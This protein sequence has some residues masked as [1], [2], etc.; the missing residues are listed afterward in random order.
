MENEILKVRKELDN[1]EISD[2]IDIDILQRFLDNFA[3]GMNIASVAV[4][5]NGT[6][7]TNPS[8]YTRI[9]SNYTHSTK[10][11]DD[12]CAECHK[13]GG[14][15]AAKSG[16]PY[17]FRC[18]A[19]LIDFAAPIMVQGRHIGTIL[20]G[21]TLTAAPDEEEFRKTAREI[22]VN[23]DE[24]VEAAKEIKI[25]DEKNIKAAAEVLFIVANALSQIGYSKLM[26]KFTSGDL[27]ENF[28]Q[29]SATMEELAASSVNMN[30]NQDKL[31][32]EIS[33][34][35]DISE[36]IIEILVSVKSI[37]DQTKLI[38]LNASIEAARAGQAGKVFS[39]VAE[40]IGNLSRNSKQTAVNIEKLTS[41]IS[42]SM[43][44]TLELSNSTM[45]NVEQQSAGIEE[46]TASIQEVLTL[47]NELYR[48]ANDK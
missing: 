25:K 6:P 1:I 22:G 28:S 18:H 26:I 44:Y 13:S 41:D 30:E 45:E 15:E 43:N 16:K 35:K 20:G 27:L 3:T 17:V 9:C 47:T 32:K 37:A 48:M 11:G 36:K 39:V 31:N 7:I 23:E 34:V 4:D 19:G 2:V 5:L 42:A 10:I 24:Y 46:T 21:Q 40:E 8:A 14:E 38:G 12:R 33:N 29:I